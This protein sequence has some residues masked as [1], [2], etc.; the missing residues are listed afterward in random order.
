MIKKTDKETVIN[1]EAVK[2]ITVYFLGIKIY[3]EINTTTNNEVVSNLTPQ[4][5]DNKIHFGVGAQTTEKTLKE[6]GFDSSEIGMVVH[7]YFKAPSP[8]TGL[9]DQ[10]YVNY[11]EIHM[12][13]IPVVQEHEREIIEL[14]NLILLLQ[15]E[16][17]ILK[18]KMEELKYA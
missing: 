7:E 14:Q 6:C 15:G 4:K 16:L 10:Y 3:E 17:S 13:T 11:D 2:I 8:Q 1:G 18:Q 5:R 12:L 9:S